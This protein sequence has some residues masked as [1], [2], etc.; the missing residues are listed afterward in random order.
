MF[1]IKGKIENLLRFSG[2]ILILFSFISSFIFDYFLFD[3]VIYFF[4][5]I[6]IIPYFIILFSIKLELNLTIENQKIVLFITM[7]NS[8]VFLIFGL[9]FFQKDLIF[10]FLISIITN[11]LL[12]VN[13]KYALSVYKKKKMIFII[14]GVFYC[15]FTITFRFF[16]FVKQM[17]FSI[18]V[19]PIILLIIGM[20]FIIITE[21]LMKKRKLINWL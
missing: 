4:I 2:F 16:I 18:S 9:I 13:W 5:I 17:L 14:T 10:P 15:I 8:I 21:L 3:F 19:L 7:L 12:I 1:S 20:L 11:Y 6:I